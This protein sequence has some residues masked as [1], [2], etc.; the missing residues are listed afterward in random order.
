MSRLFKY[1]RKSMKPVSR[2]LSTFRLWPKPRSI[3]MSG[4][5][6]KPRK[7]RKV[8]FSTSNGRMSCARIPSNPF[9]EQSQ[10]SNSFRRRSRTRAI[11]SQG[12]ELNCLKDK[13]F[14]SHF[15]KF[16]N[17][18]DLVL[19][20]AGPQTHD[21]PGGARLTQ[22]LRCILCVEK[23]RVV[24]AEN[25]SNAWHNVLVDPIVVDR[26]KLNQA[27]WISILRNLGSN[28]VL[29]SAVLGFM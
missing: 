20:I 14:L 22:G 5:F 17:Q 23:E 29:V 8:N 12:G 3:N 27:V 1:S 19:T 15:Q 7:P 10:L 21:P 28:T 2:G 24:N 18:Q 26:P 25:L 9:L 6:P 11:E 13:I 16:F 4:R